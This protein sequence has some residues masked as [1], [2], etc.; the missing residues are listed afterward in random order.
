MELKQMISNHFSNDNESVSDIN[1]SD[2]KDYSANSPIRVIMHK[3]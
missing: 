3:Y 1:F 2:F